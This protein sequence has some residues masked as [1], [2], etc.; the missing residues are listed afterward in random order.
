[1]GVQHIGSRLG[2]L[3]AGIAT[4]S[5]ALALASCGGGGDLAGVGSGGTGIRV[6]SYGPIS[7]FGSIIVNGVHYDVGAA[8]V[9][10]DDGTAP[11]PFG[12]GMVV[13]VRGSVDADGLAGTAGGITVFSEARGR[14]AAWSP[15]GF[16]VLGLSVRTTANTVYEGA[17]SVA[18][19]DYVEVFGVYDRTAAMLTATRIE[20]QDPAARFKVRGTVGAFDGD[21]RRFQLGTLVVDYSGVSPAPAGL[22]TG[23]MVR[24]HASAEPTGGVLSA[25]RV[26]VVASREL[27][28]VAKVEIDGVIDRFASAADFSVDGMRVDASNARFEGGTPADL[29]TGRRVEVEGPVAGGIVQASTIEFEDDEAREFELK[30]LV[31]GFVDPGNFVVRGMAVDA[32]GTVRY[33]DGSASDLRNGACV[34]IKGLLQQASD[35]SRILA[36]DIHFEGSCD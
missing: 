21:R 33:E 34:D 12:L 19:G 30:G 18:D 2:R 7:G 27:S 14:V 23:T 6:A 26:D 29:A 36:T 28:G 16:S 9:S 31:S 13:E 15:A 11:A 17:S 10:N 4:A 1:M 35:G 5:L 25:T 3:A 20:R 22:G 8:T 32:S 24:V